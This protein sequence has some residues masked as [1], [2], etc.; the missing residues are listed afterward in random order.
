MTTTDESVMGCWIS[1]VITNGG[2][3]QKHDLGRSSG[4]LD[5]AFACHVGQRRLTVDE[6][7]SAY[8]SYFLNVICKKISKILLSW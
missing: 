5:V 1:A 8:G 7:T 2:W 3:S 6:L 4:A